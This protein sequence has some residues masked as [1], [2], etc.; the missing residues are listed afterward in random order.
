[1][2]DDRIV[3]QMLDDISRLHLMVRNLSGNQLIFI[4]FLMSPTSPEALAEA[5]RNVRATLFGLD[6]SADRVQLLDARV[7]R[8]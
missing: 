8:G 4:E 6:E 2:E 5:A 3:L 1:M 7:R